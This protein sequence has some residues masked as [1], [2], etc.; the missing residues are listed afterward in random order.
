MKQDETITSQ[1]MPTAR[2]DR[3]GTEAAPANKN[4]LTK[5]DPDSAYSTGKPQGIQTLSPQQKEAPAVH[6]PSHQKISVPV[7]QEGRANCRTPLAA[8]TRCFSCT[9]GRETKAVGSWTLRCP[10][11]ACG[12]AKLCKS[13]GCEAAETVQ[14]GPDAKYFLTLEQQHP[15]CSARVLQLLNRKVPLKWKVVIPSASM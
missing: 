8:L 1:Q 10:R 7:K 2:T 12:E 9:P 5:T 15:A 11:E 13:W 3:L 6:D 14:E 4:S